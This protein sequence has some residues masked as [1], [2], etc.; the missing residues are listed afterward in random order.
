MPAKSK[1]N[2][3]SKKD[4]QSNQPGASA[5][6]NETQDVENDSELTAGESSPDVKRSEPPT[7]DAPQ[8]ASEEIAK[9]QEIAQEP[10][11]TTESQKGEHSKSSVETK[12]NEEGAREGAAAPPAQPEGQSE[13]SQEQPSKGGQMEESNKEPE[14]STQEGNTSAS[15]GENRELDST[16]PAGGENQTQ[17]QPQNQ[18]QSEPQSSEA[19]DGSPKKQEEGESDAPQPKPANP[20]E[21]TAA[22]EPSPTGEPEP[23]FEAQSANESTEPSSGF[24]KLMESLEQERNDLDS[25][26]EQIDAD[27]ERQLLELVQKRVDCEE[28]VAITHDNA[29][30]L[31]EETA[32]MDQEIR[33]LPTEEQLNTLRQTLSERL[34]SLGDRHL[35]QM[36]LEFQLVV[37]E[38][39]EHAEKCLQTMLLEM[40]SDELKRLSGYSRRRKFLYGA[41]ETSLDVKDALDTVAAVTDERESQHAAAHANLCESIETEQSTDQSY[42]TDKGSQQHALK[43]LLHEREHL[44]TSL[45]AAWAT[46]KAEILKK[47][48]HFEDINREQLYH[49]RR[50]SSVQKSTVRT[51][52]EKREQEHHLFLQR[53]IKKATTQYEQLCAEMLELDAAAQ[54]LLAEVERS[55]GDYEVEHARRKTALQEAKDF[56]KLLTDEKA[57]WNR[58]KEDL[59]HCRRKIRVQWITEAARLEQEAMIPSKNWTSP[60]PLR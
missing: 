32:E 6:T 51:E 18:T 60:S 38:K 30:L 13:R 27:T 21:G 15:T 11:Q 5:D 57:E 47:K 42:F 14:P 10:S 56:V 48:R 58:L 55:R 36:D 26:I 25:Q 45:Q 37:E 31:R 46:D 44:M 59:E 50:G 9:P 24:N 2:K 20:E 17:V 28:K 12:A 7:V 54:H 3:K 22:A 52:E 8:P 19:D 39:K 34:Q 40:C 29:R 53:E 49:L 23:E 1:K 33:A 35:R 43:T 4:Q 41:L 16:T